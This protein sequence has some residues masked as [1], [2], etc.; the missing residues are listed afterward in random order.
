MNSQQEIAQR[1]RQ[2]LTEGAIYRASLAASMY[3]VRQ[4][5]H[6]DSL[7]RRAAGFVTTTAFGM[8]KGKGLIGTGINLQ[9]MLPFAIEAFSLLPKKPFIK[10]ILRTT[11]VVA[12]A[13]GT[14][15]MFLRKKKSPQQDNEDKQGLDETG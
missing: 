5:L 14:A 2:L 10:K 11:A 9:S 3:D 13:V 7:A 15:N 12:A 8:I 4:N 6:A 1:K